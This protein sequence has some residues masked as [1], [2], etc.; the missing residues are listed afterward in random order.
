ML[1]VSGGQRAHVGAIGYSHADEGAE[2]RADEREEVVEEGDGFGDEEADED[3]EEDD[4]AGWSVNVHEGGLAGCHYSQ[5][6]EVVRLGVVRK[7]LRVAQQA[8]KDWSSA[9]A[10]KRWSLS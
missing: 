9:H 7:V 10:T 5:P 1:R 3:V 6:D 2:E 4:A 8:D